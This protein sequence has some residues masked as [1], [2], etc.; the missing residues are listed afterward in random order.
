MSLLPQNATPLERDIE[1][2]QDRLL[3][4]NPDEITRLYRPHQISSALLP[5]LAWAFDVPFWPDDPQLKRKLVADSWRL[6]RLRGTLGGMKA[7]AGYQDAEIVRAITPPAKVHLSPSL[8]VDERNEFL[9]RYPQ[10]RIYRYRTYGQRIGAMLHR[11]FTNA[12]SKH[13]PLISDAVQRFLPRAYLWRSGT[14]TEL[15]ILERQQ[16]ISQRETLTITEIRQPATAGWVSFCN[17]PNF[18]LRHLAG[19]DAAKR[20]YRLRLTGS[21][22]DRSEVLRRE[23]HAPGL[24]LIDV[25][26]DSVAETGQINPHAGVFI[27]RF[28]TGRIALT[29]AQDRLYQRFYLFDPEIA[30][31][32]RGASLFIGESRLGMPPH[33]AEL[34][35]KVL[36]VIN[37]RAASRF[38][39]GYLVDPGKKRLESLLETLRWMMRASDRIAIDTAP[40]R[41]L[42]S[43]EQFMAGDYVAGQWINR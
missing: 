30:R 41:Q 36:G 27:N 37:R 9:Q 15:S 18:P 24:S 12:G 42:R 4:I 22:T 38:V 11:C 23:T 7:I 17:R 20:L 10:L 34:L 6:H 21:Y 31:L 40:R 2:T 35:I 26:Y 19:S 33:H 43:G 25:R 32:R 29:T 16:V 14:E 5:W 8:T 28:I 13:W 1:Q 39:S 3:A